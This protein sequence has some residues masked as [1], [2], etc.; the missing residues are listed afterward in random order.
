MANGLNVAAYQHA[1]TFDGRHGRLGPT[2]YCPFML[3]IE[4]IKVLNLKHFQVRVIL[5]LSFK[6]SS[7]SFLVYLMFTILTMTSIHHK[8]P[9]NK[10]N[11]Y[12][13]HPKIN[14]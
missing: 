6:V 4:L 3:D 10:H 8:E 12:N 9:L 5:D 1:T 13:I 11:M 14:R 2:Q 7:F